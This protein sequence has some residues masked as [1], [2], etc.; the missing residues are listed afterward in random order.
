M[1]NEKGVQYASLWITSCIILHAF[2]MDHEADGRVPRDGF[3]R[4]GCKIM[5]SERREHD[6]RPAEMEEQM[7]REAE[8]GEEGREIELLEGRLKRE[9]L[10]KELFAELVRYDDME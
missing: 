6:V 5:E 7:A 10:K 4:E 8:D 1:D 9:E 3:F 2:A